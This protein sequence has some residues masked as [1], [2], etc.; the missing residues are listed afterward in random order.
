MALIISNSSSGFPN[1]AKNRFVKNGTAN[2]GRNIPTEICGPPPEVIPNIP[3][4]RNRNG[5]FHL[6]SNRNFRNL[7]HNGKHPLIA[8]EA[9]K[10]RSCQSFSASHTGPRADCPFHRP[11]VFRPAVIKSVRS[12]VTANEILLTSYG[13]NYG[14]SQE[15]IFS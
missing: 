5:P 8:P 6:N 9:R 12:P 3:V 10:E 15:V 7:W 11:A 2:F 13:V 1:K 4:R 14:G